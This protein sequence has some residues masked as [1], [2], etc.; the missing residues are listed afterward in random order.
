MDRHH[1]IPISMGGPDISEN[2][3]LINKR[4]HEELHSNQKVCYRKIR[5]YREK[6]NHILIPNQ[7]CLDAEEDLLLLYFDNAIT[8]VKEQQRALANVILFYQKQ[9]KKDLVY[10][11]NF[12]GLLRALKQSKLY[13][14]NRRLK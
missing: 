5:Q 9:G 6:T 12:E 1:N 4:D 10:D 14:I 13:L 11:Y 7:Y 2:T 8:Y 3:F